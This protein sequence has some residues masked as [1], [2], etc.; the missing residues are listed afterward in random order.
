ML[1]KVLC[2]A[3]TAMVLVVVIASIALAATVCQPGKTH[4]SAPSSTS[5]TYSNVVGGRKGIYNVHWTAA[6][7]YSRCIF[8]KMAEDPSLPSD[9]GRVYGYG[10]AHATAYGRT[11]TH[12]QGYWGHDCAQSN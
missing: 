8:S 6:R 4:L 2:T 7:C 10:A 5:F 3:V 12:A 1:K 11:G 9:S